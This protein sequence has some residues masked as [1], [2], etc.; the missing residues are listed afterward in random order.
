MA[1]AT[2]FELFLSDEVQSLI[3]HF[4]AVLDLRVTFFSI[5][6]RELRRGRQMRNCDYCAMVQQELGSLKQC[7]AMDSEKRNEAVASHGIIDYRCHAGLREAIAPVFIHDKLAGFLMIGQFRIDDEI[8]KSMLVR[9]VDAGQRK[10]LSDAFRATPKI[11]AEKLEDM[12]GLFR[13]LIDYICVRELAV[14]QGDQLRHD[15]DRY[16]ELHYAEDIRLPEMARKL[17][18]SVSTISQFLRRNCRTGF[19]ELLTERR[20]E[21][22]EEFWRA[23]PEAT[24]GEAADAAGFSD[25]FYFSRVFRKR[26]GLPPGEYRDRLRRASR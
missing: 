18:R 15:I 25:Q 23:N 9:C 17:G 10:R 2:A 12:L 20:L 1:A 11:N 5:D 19:K 6:G 26:R 24:V 7:L 3:D 14:L 4:A 8:P 21:K 16:I 22:A 13:M